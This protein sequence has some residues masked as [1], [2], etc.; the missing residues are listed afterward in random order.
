M[1]SF[2]IGEGV[3]SGFTWGYGKVL[4]PQLACVHGNERI[5]L[6]KKHV[7]MT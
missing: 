6:N 4:L 3:V 7:Y 1:E 5:K 2:T